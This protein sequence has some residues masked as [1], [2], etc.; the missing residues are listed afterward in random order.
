ME[1]NALERT[2]FDDVL[3]IQLDVPINATL[4]VQ[5]ES[6]DMIVVPEINNNGINSI[7]WG[8]DVVVPQV[9]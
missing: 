5:D 3:R 1:L 8:S 9:S 4:T 2:F 7:K 6:I